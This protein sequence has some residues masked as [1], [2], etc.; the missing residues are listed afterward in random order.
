[1]MGLQDGIIFFG[2]A[3]HLHVYHRML[4]LTVFKK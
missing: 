2:V 4:K 3:T 1:M